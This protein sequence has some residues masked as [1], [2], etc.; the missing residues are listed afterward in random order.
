M[1]RPTSRLKSADLPTFGR[2]TIETEPTLSSSF[3]ADMM[4]LR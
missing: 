2:P 4:T 3:L 1:F